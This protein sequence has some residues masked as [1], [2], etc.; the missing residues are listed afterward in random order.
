MNT[1]IALRAITALQT[2][3]GQLLHTQTAEIAYLSDVIET[4]ADDAG[5]ERC[6]GC[7]SYFES[8]ERGMC[9]KCNTEARD[10]RETLDDLSSRMNQGRL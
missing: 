7:R 3:R 5:L 2:I 8:L 6:E 1:Q 10:E 4:I 9:G